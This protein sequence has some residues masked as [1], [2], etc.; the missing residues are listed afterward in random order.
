MGV[1]TKVLRGPVRRS[2]LRVGRAERA[3]GS[4]VEIAHISSR[5]E[6]SSGPGKWSNT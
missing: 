3:L 5:G 4:E 1:T 2:W 6:C